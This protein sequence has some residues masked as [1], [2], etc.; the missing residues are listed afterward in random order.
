[1]PIDQLTKDFLKE[2]EQRNALP[3]PTAAPAP[4]AGDQ[5][6]GKSLWETIGTEE[7]PD[8]LQMKENKS[9]AL[10]FAGAALWHAFDVG[11]LGLHRN[12]IPFFGIFFI[13]SSRSLF[14]FIVL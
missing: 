4:A 2:L 13:N 8:W 12:T 5:A 7:E 11:L 3:A 10:H 9:G 1:M 14:R 6:T